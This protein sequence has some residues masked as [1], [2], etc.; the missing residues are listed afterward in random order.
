MKKTADRRGMTLVEVMLTVMII[1]MLAVVMIPAIKSSMRGRD[2]AEC[3][4]KLRVAVEAFE[5]YAAET[6]GYPPDQAVPSETTVPEMAAYYFPYFKIDWWAD[7][8]PLGGRWDWD[9]GYHGYAF[10]VSIWKPDVSEEQMTDLDRLIDDGDLTTGNFRR[11][12]TQY[13]YILED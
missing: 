8:T 2:N 1:G 10:S 7:A 9:V 6:G 5:L 13:H 3:A 11:Q 12:G 4:R